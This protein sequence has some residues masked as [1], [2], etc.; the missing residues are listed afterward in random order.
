MKHDA[1]RSGGSGGSAV[2]GLHRSWLLGMTAG[3]W[4]AEW[5]QVVAVAAV[6]TLACTLVTSLGLLV[7]AT[8]QG[9]VRGALTALP[10]DQTTLDVRVLNPTAS[11]ERSRDA[12]AGSVSSVL[13]DSA[14]FTSTGM[15]LTQLGDVSGLGTEPALTYFGE[16]DDISDHASIVEGAWADAVAV[17]TD[18]AQSDAATTDAATTDA[19]TTDAAVPVALPESAARAV[20]LTVGSTLDVAFGTGTTTA[21]VVGLYRADDPTDDFWTN[22]V[23]HGEGNDPQF[24]RPGVR[25]YDPM[26]AF[27]PLIASPGAIDAADVPVS[28]IDIAYAPEFADT[29]VD[30]LAP[31]IDRLRTAGIDIPSQAGR[32]GESIF[33]SSPTADAVTAVVSGLVVTRSTVVVISLLLVVLALAAMT[34]TARV[35]TDA[36]DT[37]QQLMRSRGASAA[38]VLAL[39]AVEACAI[40]AVA[41]LASPPLA[42]LVY[43]LL[44]IQP[45]MVAAGMP[46]DVAIS[47][48][49]W[50]TAS[51][52]AVLVVVVLVAPVA[53]LPWRRE[54]TIVDGAQSKTRQRRL[55]G[56]MRSGL[57][58]GLIF[59]AAIAYW[60]LW[61]YRTTIGGG[62]S[63]AVD[64]VLAAGPALVLLA[65]ALLCARLIPVAARL[66]ER[67]GS[68]ARGMV[69][70][71]A[72]WEIGRRTQRATA[73]VLLL[74]LALAV[75]TF[76]LSFLTTWQNSQ[77]DQAA[78]A[79]GAP[80]RALADPATASEQAVDLAAGAQGEAQPAIHRSARVAGPDAAS[81]V[82]E[83]AAG[84]PAQVLALSSAARNMIADGRVGD[85]GGRKL[86]ESLA[87]DAA[88]SGG[89]QLPG[90]VDRLSATVQIGD[91]ATA[92]PGVNAEVRAILEGASGLLTTVSF[93]EV[94]ADG[95]VHAVE[96]LVGVGAE[97]TGEENTGDET[98]DAAGSTRAEQL[99]FVGL[100]TVFTGTDP[101]DAVPDEAELT[102]LFGD[103]GV[104]QRGS[105]S[106]QPVPF[107]A[108]AASDAYPAWFGTSGDAADRPPV[109]G[110][111]G[112]QL[113]L[114]VLIPSTVDSRPASFAM[115]GWKPVTELAAVVPT[116]FASTFN[117]DT[118]SQ[119]TLRV[120]GQ[121]VPIR[122]AG[123]VPLVPGAA[124]VTELATAGANIPAADSR[125]ATVVVDESALS[126]A[127]AQ[128]GLSGPFVD[129]WWIDVAAGQ[130]QAYTDAYTDAR[131]EARPADSAAGTQTTNLAAASVVSRDGLARQLQESPL[132]VAT[133]AA[134]WL[135]VIAGALLAA[136][137]FIVNIIAALR[138]R[139]LEL[140]HLQAIGTSRGALSA[141]LALESLLLCALGTVFGIAI[142]LL[143]VW[144]V[145]PLVA[146]S[147]DGTTPVPAVVIDIPWAQL[148]L[149]A[150]E[151]GAVLAVVV[152]LTA[153][154]QRSTRPAELL[155]EGGES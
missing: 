150:L 141:L 43:R 108:D 73:A 135:G 27:G 60:Q 67:A 44:A 53:P 148:A 3:R 25:F 86:A 9:G 24:P 90:D 126:R 29:T 130:G 80:V 11:I 16:L 54:R 138:A 75:G 124:T 100:Q 109:P 93:G 153:I 34:Q 70:P 96:A 147:P 15:V 35:F 61:L 8:E 69:L 32:L 41:V 68:G 146:L 152:A 112:R 1:R 22:D 102:V 28:F 97:D 106:V 57:D 74:S 136:V 36:R 117:V 121:L 45:P 84:V 120:Q 113:S 30:Q 94:E 14:T 98:P 51:V 116:A 114:E 103:L 149:L 142:G 85:E 145:G 33:V 40:G 48:I 56:F 64:P 76:S 101:G 155:R 77:R 105:M 39:G 122:L 66:I 125:D 137:G 128:A 154:V 129:E 62:A 20:G 87:G 72:S 107:D 144:L 10:T 21:Q 104:T 38:H 19:A 118:G 89:V 2:R 23:L 71:L 123:T 127:L 4:R 31:L 91:T 55:S 7:T 26:E 47:P 18:A 42:L 115:V 81:G 140:A 78:L 139:R 99:R 5:R 50:L 58:L 12:L 92:L 133:Q 134:L 111:A 131:S 65:G 49:T 6:A 79:V 46:T 88:V 52:M 95:E 119:L 132:R 151:V 13:G 17:Q 37:E 82:G 59:L 143:L 63:L 110:Q 83:P